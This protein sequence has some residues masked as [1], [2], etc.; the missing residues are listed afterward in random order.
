MN[1]WSLRIRVGRG[2]LRH[3]LVRALPICLVATACQAG[4]DAAE[5]TTEQVALDVEAHVR[6]F[7][8]ANST[9]DSN[10]I[11]SLLW[12][13][14]RM[15]VDGRWTQYGDVVE[16]SREYMG[17]LSAFHTV[18]TDLQVVPLSSRFAVASFS[19]RD[20]VIASDGTVTLAQGPTSLVWE[21]RGGTWKMIFGDADH[22]PVVTAR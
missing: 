5:F 17:S 20:S 15:R 9:L 11:V 1:R 13:E 19:F 18:W 4:P 12:P 10:E 16:G 3:R 21:R 7:E 2:R 6:R 22:Y 14:F 8:R